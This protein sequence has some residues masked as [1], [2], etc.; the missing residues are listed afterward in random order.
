LPEKLAA[1]QA[2]AEASAAKLRTG[3]FDEA[4]TRVKP[5]RNYPRCPCSHRI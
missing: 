1:R 5:G 2:Q 4:L 3:G